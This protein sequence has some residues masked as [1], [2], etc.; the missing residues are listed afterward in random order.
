MSNN[1]KFKA[2]TEPP[3]PGW[4][5]SIAIRFCIFRSRRVRNRTRF[6]LGGVAGNPFMEG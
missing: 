5:V 6:V 1:P 3:A 4:R 2:Q